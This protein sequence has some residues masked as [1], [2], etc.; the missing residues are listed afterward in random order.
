MKKHS[1][2][3][4]VCCG[5][6]FAGGILLL[7]ACSEAK[8]YKDTSLPPAE[9]AALLLKEMTLEEKIGQMCQYVGPSHVEEN[10]KKQGQ[11]SSD[12]NN[13]DANAFGMKGQAI[14]E[15]VRKGQ[16]GAFLHVLNVEEA[17]MLQKVAQETRLQIPLL[18]GVDAIHGNGLHAGCTVY[19]TSIT[20]ASSFNPDLME[21]SGA[22]TALEMRASGMHWAFNPNLDVAR[23]PRWGRIG[24]TFGEDTY[25]VTQM[26]TRLIQG[27][28]G[29][30]GVQP[31]RVLACA[32]HMIA[33]GEPAGGINA[34]PMD[35]SEQKLR[36]VFLPPFIAAV[37]AKVF[38]FMAAH[39]ELNGIPC[40]A[41]HWMLKDLLRK[42]MGFDGFVVSDWM[43]IERL[44][45]MH[46]YSPT[47]EEAF[48]VSVEAG[49]DMHMQGDNYF[50]TVLAAVQSGRIPESRIDQAVIKILE[51]KFLLGLFENPIV[52]I[53]ATRSQIAPEA[54][55]KTAL[56]SARQGMVLLKNN[57]I[58]PLKKDNY[59]RIFIA[60][61]N[62]DSQT[63]L[64]D[65]AMPQPDENVIT[66][67][68][69]IR[70]ACPN[71]K[72]DSLC[73]GGRITEISSNDLVVANR[74]AR[75]A[76]LNIVVL[77][78]NSQRYES[79]GRTC[80]ENC[81]RDNL[82]L[83]GRQ[84][85][86]LEAIYASGKPTILVLLN[87]RP[88]SLVWADQNIPAILEA[89]EPGMYGGQVIA[90]VLFGDLNPSGKLPVTVP[91][92]VGQ[93]QT[94]YNHKWSQ[95]SR[96]FALSHTG[97]LYPFGYGLSYTTYKYGKPT[98]S[99]DKINKNE[100]VTI[101]FDLTNTG[102]KDGTEIVQLYIR[103]EYGSITRPVKEL[104]GFQRVALK[105]GETKKV[106]FTITPDDLKFYTIRKV[107]EVEPGDFTIMVGA[108]SADEDLQSVALKVE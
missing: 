79:F 73:F 14:I 7:D 88:L 32:K 102:K 105:A 90:E 28:Q 59:R 93:V 52:D 13:I 89:W 83:P 87:G 12:M 42:E 27:L 99:K 3:Q 53:E 56:E 101:S 24:E 30:D 39:N 54:H 41:N 61:P 68:E 1:L 107:W 106:E 8:S 100:S 104:K 67:Y 46:H 44:H 92:N 22:E 9:R 70:D 57:G 15:K 74:K 55:R 38:T 10:E 18:F 58:L 33:G 34:A 84:Q 94:I 20:M 96:K 108:S 98:L 81:D 51:A 60:G 43:D 72:I 17:N 2:K 65:W 26:G 23:D 77:G 37:N 25:L 62:A 47:Q 16:A 66:V 31:D 6:M 80:G 76:D 82:D 21:Q 35:L 91:Y 36:E 78:E 75:E 29:R 40:H 11:S 48:C 95:Y 69:G 50:E 103:D 97:Y 71:A 86:L 19:P 64:G 4:Y 85:E 63:I 45:S 5:L 49:I